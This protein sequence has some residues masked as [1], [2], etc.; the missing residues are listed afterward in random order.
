MARRHV[1]LRRRDERLLVVVVDGGRHAAP[2]PVY[3]ITGTGGGDEKY[4]HATLDVSM[5]SRVAEV[6]RKR[7]Q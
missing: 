2:E 7:P 3:P 5:G 4:G 6:P 1:V